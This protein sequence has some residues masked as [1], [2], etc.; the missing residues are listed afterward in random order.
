MQ[1]QLELWECENV[2]KPQSPDNFSSCK[3]N[4]MK[5]D[6]YPHTVARENE[7]EKRSRSIKNGEKIN[8]KKKE[9][10]ITLKHWAPNHSTFSSRKI[11]EERKKENENK[12]KNKP[13][14]DFLT[15]CTVIIFRRIILLVSVSPCSCDTFAKRG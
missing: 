2:L 1:T 3:L 14:V 7:M 8:E 10:K 6:L 4:G 13:I 12:S 11:Y 15:W 5:I 9:R